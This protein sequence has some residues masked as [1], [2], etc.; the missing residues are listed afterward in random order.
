M[1]ETVSSNN[2]PTKLFSG[3]ILN[4]YTNPNMI[5][6]KYHDASIMTLVANANEIRENNLKESFK[7]EV[8]KLKSEYLLD[9]YVS[10]FLHFLHKNGLII[11]RPLFCKKLLSLGKLTWNFNKIL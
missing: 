2:F 7:L 3:N 11:F 1:Y 4:V 8:L 5:R 6:Q 9:Y 10:S